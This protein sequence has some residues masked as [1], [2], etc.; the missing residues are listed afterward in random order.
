MT[1]KTPSRGFGRGPSR[2][3]ARQLRL[4]LGQLSRTRKHRREPRPRKLRAYPEMPPL[5]R[6]YVLPPGMTKSPSPARAYLYELSKGEG[7]ETFYVGVT[8]RHLSE[9]LAQHVS[10]AR[11]R[12]GKNCRL[13]AHIRR[14]AERGNV[15]VMR[16]HSEHAV[17]SELVAAE[18]A[19]IAALR[20][21]LGDR[22]LNLGPGGETAPAGRL[23]PEGERERAHLARR[24]RQRDE[25][26]RR[27]LSLA[28][29]YRHPVGALEAV[30]RDFATADLSVTLRTI[31]HRHQI[32]ETI[33]SGILAGR[34]NGLVLDPAVLAAARAAQAH[35]AALRR[36]ADQGAATAIASV[37]RDYLA[38]PPGF[39]LTKAAR[40]R[41][42]DHR[43]VQEVLRGGE[44]G[45]PPSFAHAIRVRMDG[46][47]RVRG[48]ALG[49]R[50]GRIDRRLL[51]ALL[52]AYSRPGSRLTLAGIAAR[53]GVTQS[54]ISHIVAGR[55]GRPLPR[56]LARA[57]RIHVAAVRRAALRSRGSR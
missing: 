17:G 12:R 53:L 40:G 24:A 23:V 54:A 52:T 5:R 49:Q 16:V 8:I 46:D 31:C 18:Q 2:T 30:L 1:R 25:G 22:L 38:G 27:N 20:A 33:V 35:R 32:G 14:I 7:G 3:S 55:R 56:R 6:R 34:T 10:F 21:T 41:G 47:A 36:Q 19:R 28:H 13:E 57:C 50:A 51:R 39:S 44:R 42:L 43:R 9:R 45:I 26:Y 11:Y 15:L 29:P 4:D 48:R 37:L